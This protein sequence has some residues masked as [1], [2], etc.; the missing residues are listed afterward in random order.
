MIMIMN[1]MSMMMTVV[2]LLTLPA[3]VVRSL[4]L[5]VTSDYY[6]WSPWCLMIKHDHHKCWS[7]K[8][9][10]HNYEDKIT[11]VCMA[12]W[13]WFRQWFKKKIFCIDNNDVIDDDN[14]VYMSYLYLIA[15]ISIY[16]QSF[17]LTM[18]EEEGRKFGWWWS[19][20]RGAQVVSD[21]SLCIYNT[22]LI[23]I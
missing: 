17:I 14:N 10:Q 4:S 5:P 7:I 20:F 12:G 9:D 1:A 8:C 23:P 3:A 21:I 6:C 18:A 16:F 19:P 2:V 15:Y 22:N 11:N 13:P